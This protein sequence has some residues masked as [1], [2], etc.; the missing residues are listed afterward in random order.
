VKVLRSAQLKKVHRFVHFIIDRDKVSSADALA[1]VSSAVRE[2]VKAVRVRADAQQLRP[3]YH[4]LKQDDRNRHQFTLLL[5]MDPA[6]LS[7]DSLQVGAVMYHFVC[8]S[9]KTACQP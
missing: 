3:I 6:T 4:Y 8:A 9:D 7:I 1:A 2:F 5:V